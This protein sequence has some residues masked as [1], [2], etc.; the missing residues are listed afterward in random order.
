MKYV[1]DDGT[2]LKIG[3]KPKGL[4][5]ILEFEAQ[6]GLD[7]FS[8]S[9][10]GGVSNMLAQLFLAYWAAGRPVKWSW[11]VEHDID[12]LMDGFELEQGDK[13]YEAAASPVDAVDPT[14]PAAGGETDV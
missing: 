2:E 3:V 10:G 8:V 6:S 4:A 11:L 5:P 9:N 14:V 1:L 7:F 12:T 13:G